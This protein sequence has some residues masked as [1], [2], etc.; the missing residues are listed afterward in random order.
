MWF[1]GTDKERKELGRPDWKLGRQDAGGGGNGQT[2]PRRVIVAFG[3]GCGK[4]GTRVS[5][6][7]C[8]SEN[9]GVS[10]GNLETRS[11]G[12]GIAISQR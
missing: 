5:S 10:W 6:D 3:L 1:T 2:G 7:T 12:K 11:E 9:R 8:T 4:V